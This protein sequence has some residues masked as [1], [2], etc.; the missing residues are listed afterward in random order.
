[1]KKWEK[2]DTNINKAC[3]K[4]LDRHS[5]YL[6]GRHTVFPLW[7]KRVNKEMKDEIANALNIIGRQFL[8]SGKPDI[9][10]VYEDR[11]LSNFITPD[12]WLLFQ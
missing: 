11:K 4:K 1:L 7:S 9:L 8:S 6:S 3:I 2:T 10:R 5:L 12:S